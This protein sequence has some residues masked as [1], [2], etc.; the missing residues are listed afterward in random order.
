VGRLLQ[1]TKS[2]RATYKFKGDELYVRARVTA[3]RPKSPIV[4]PG[5]LER[6]WTQP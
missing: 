4:V 5:E 1:A 2:V 6:A 3:Y